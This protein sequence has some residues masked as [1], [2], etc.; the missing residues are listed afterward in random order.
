MNILYIDIDS[1][2][3][4]H[5]GCYGYQRNTSPNIDAIASEGLRFRNCYTPDAP[6]LPSRSAMTTGR[7][8]IHT[9]VVNHGG[10]RAVMFNYGKDRAFRDN[11]TDRNWASQMKNNGYHTVAFSPFAER[12]GAWHWYA[13][14]MEIHNTGGGGQETADMIAPQVNDWLDRKGKEDKPFFMWLNVWDPHTPYRTPK[15]FTNPFK[16]EPIPDWYTEEVRQQHW[17][18]PG[19]HSAQEVN[20]Y[21]PDPQWMFNHP[22]ENPIHALQPQRISDMHEARKM[23]DG[24]DMGVSY[25]DKHVGEIIQKL[26]TLGLYENTAIIISADHGENLG[27]LNVYGDHQTADQFTHNIP[28]IVRWPGVTDGR[29]G[30]EDSRMMYNIDLAATTLELAGKCNLSQWDGKSFAETIGK[31]A[32]HRENLVLSQMAW[33]TQRSARWDHYICIETYHDSWHDYPDF[34]VFDLEADPHEQVNLAETRPDLIQKGKTILA[35]WKEQCMATAHIKED[36][37]DTVIAEGG[38]LHARDDIPAYLQRLRD[39]GRAEAAE[40]LKRKHKVVE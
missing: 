29:A 10:E 21:Q 36:P 37:L 12:H 28:M 6:C 16:Q 15:D 32:P 30:Q 9:G 31:E 38:S 23:F 4:D 25:A 2:R 8:G 3:P 39:T 5:L 24:Y 11:W 33:C 26:K 17:Q 22:P 13:G 20:G 18:Q 1:L 7:F 35:E 34:M 27:E 14:F 40:R 19:P